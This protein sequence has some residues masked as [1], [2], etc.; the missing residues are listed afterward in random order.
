MKKRIVSLILTTAMILALIGCSGNTKANESAPKAENQATQDSQETAEAPSIMPK[1]GVYS[2]SYEEEMDGVNYTFTS[3]LFLNGDGTGTWVVQDTCD[4]TYD[5]STMSSVYNGEVFESYTYEY[6]NNS[7]F[8]NEG[9]FTNEYKFTSA[10]VPSDIPAW[11]DEQNPT[12]DAG[13]RVE[14][15]P[16]DVDPKAPAD[17]EYNL[18]M[19]SYEDCQDSYG[20]KGTL[21]LVEKYDAEAVK[22]LQP[23]D[24]VVVDG[25]DME[26]ATVD[27]SGSL[28]L[29]NGGEE[30]GGVCFRV[31]DDQP[32]CQVAGMDDFPTFVECG[33]INLFV[34]TDCVITDS[35][36]IMEH[37]DGIVYT[38]AEFKKAMTDPT[39]YWYWNTSVII[40]DGNI[41]EINIRFV[42]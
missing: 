6:K 10:D 32:Y 22:A 24:T 40:K 16:V 25:N 42:P 26:V 8:L 33:A 39:D 1:A 15:I 23:G 37:P 35:S 12:A 11:L 28:I 19:D 38:P 30:E 4:I 2:Y 34:P 13:V 41:V 36:D 3:Y 21:Y 14:P 7:I 29:I 9:D 20:I 18:W 17:G 27:F 31:Y 5:D